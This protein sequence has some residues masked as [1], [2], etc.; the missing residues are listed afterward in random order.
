MENYTKLNRLLGWLVFLIATLTYF[1]TLEPTASWWDCGEYI[2][3]AYK[4][5]VGHPPGAPLFQ[6]LGRFFSLF[7]FGD[8]SK[9]AMMVNVMSA[10][11]SSFTVLFLFWTITMLGR[12][13]V[14]GKDEMTSGMMYAIFGSG[15]V[16]ALAFT[17]SDSFWFSAVEG[18][19]YA[20]SSFFTAITFWAILRWEK[21]ANESHSLRWILLIAF[22]IGLSIGVHMLNLLAIPAIAFV[23]YFKK[24]KTS[25]KGVL[26]TLAVGMTVL[27]I[28]MYVIIPGVVS[29]S[30]AFEL[31]FVNSI[32]LPF[33]TGTLVY[34]LVLVALILIGIRYTHRNKR[35]LFNTV[36][37]SFVFI[38]IGYS[39]F[40]MLI[41]RS[42]ENPPI[43]E[44]SPEDAISLLSYLNREQY[45][46]W[47]KV[48][49]QYYTAP[50]VDY[51]DGN[52]QYIRDEKSGKYVI[53]DRRTGTIPVYDKRFMTIFPR[54]WSN[55]KPE[56]KR[57]YNQYAKNART[58]EVEGQPTKIPSF[59][60]NLGFFFNYQLGHMY[61]RY[62]MWN[63]VG[64]QD[65]IEAQPG[66]KNGNWLSG[67][68]F[69]DN[70]RLGSQENLPYT[71]DNP[72][73]NKFYFLPLLLGLIGLYFHFRSSKKDTL[74]VALLFFM[75]GIAIVLYLNQYPYQPRERDYAYAGSFYA[76][77]IWIG[78]GVM[79]LYSWIKKYMGGSSLLAGGITLISLVLVPGI[80]AQQGWDDHDR[81]GK[82]TAR[83][84]GMN[85]LASCDPDAVLI[86]NGDNDTF[87]LWYVQEVEGFRTDVR[88]VNYM[89]SSGYWYVHQL[90]RKVYD[91]EPLP[92]TLTPEQYEKGRNQYLMYVDRGIK[93]RVEVKDLVNFIASD[94][95]RT[96]IPL[97]TGDKINYIPT[98]K[99][100]LTVDSAKCVDNGIVPRELAHLIVPYIEWDIK[101]NALYK[102][103]LML[104]DFLATN[105]WER[106]LYFAN[107]NSI[108]RV[109]DVDEYCHLEGTVYKFMPV[110]AKE[111]IPALGGIN[112][113]KSYEF[114]MNDFR[115]G[116][117][118]DPT[119]VVDRET[120]R[121]SRILRQNFLRISQAL[122]NE[123]K[124]EQAVDVIDTSTYYLSHDKIHYD[125]LMLPIIEIY[126]EGG[127]I[128]K[129]NREIRKL[130]EVCDQELTY[131]LS[132][133]PALADAIYSTEMQQDIAILRRIV[134]VTELN[135][136][137][138][139]SEE[140]EAIL[141]KHLEIM[142]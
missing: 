11:S 3:T 84:F 113:D 112:T 41:I 114:I 83:D 128:E 58:I 51:D 136:Q 135:D 138:E 24:Y 60:D 126:Y 96:K 99:L 12:K 66:P 5:Q 119:V 65:N 7:A 45:G 14:V 37:L 78:L 87:P 72:A 123:G 27:S 31:F 23:Y 62:F 77:A 141:M 63:F 133:D 76:F 64:R 134:E 33:N 85:Y 104:L 116:N 86:T 125:I 54:M 6:M 111:Y 121:H 90:G 18:E 29:L 1:L 102:N 118:D 95:D 88:V 50:I 81:S 4:L 75:T 49:G 36:I 110:K 108:E 59:G 101:Q 48:Y 98:K 16:G 109:F 73:R 106:P 97:T 26:I 71:M 10:L 30:T 131:F 82:Y 35:V 53:T 39:S 56:H 55:Q 61:F 34:F 57:M 69:I 17:F 107:P 2:A 122:K 52:P 44:N 32:G 47:P 103:D 28:L 9:V 130:L 93:G 139:L 117:L 21:V 124:I 132:I 105:N 43:D 80:M 89:L 15:L 40:F 137:L 70:N 19:V 20:M 94:D 91:S 100:R 13:L 79:G 38:L 127:E 68:S 42:N 25:T 22:L 120:Y 67:I 92:L 8:T 46:T 115:W 129:G 74:V 142:E 140:A